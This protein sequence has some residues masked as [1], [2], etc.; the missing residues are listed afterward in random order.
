MLFSDFVS[1]ILFSYIFGCSGLRNLALELETN[2]VCKE[3]GLSKTPFST[4][5]DGFSRFEGQKVKLLFE[6]VLSNISLLQSSYLDELGIFNVID[7]SL[8]PT[9]LPANWTSYRKNK[10]A[11][12]MHFCFELNRMIA[13]EF[14][15][16]NGHSCER[17]IFTQMVH[18]GITYIAD[19]GYFS[20][21]IALKVSSSDAFFILR[22]KDNMLFNVENRLDVT[23]ENFPICFR[24]AS[25]S[26]GK[27]TNDIHQSNIRIVRFEVWGNAFVIATNRLDLTTFQIILLYAY[28]WQI[29]LFFK[30][31]KRTLKG[32][33]LL[34]NTEN[35]V[36]IQFYLL[37]T[38][39][40]L[41]LHLKQTCQAIKNISYFFSDYER[42][43][44]EVY[45]FTGQ[46]PSS[47]IKNAA[48]PFYIFWK[49]SKAWL[50]VLKS[51][52]AQLFDNEII[53]ILS[54]A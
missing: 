22:L 31:L 36:Q 42:K 15:V 24:N 20:F 12:K 50:T 41:E 44:T 38:L 40:L 28:R 9:L 11:F 8:F 16:G 3:L 23:G 27:F 49:I 32:C 48:K 21:D 29:E 47:W 25:D 35:G 5:K 14:W 19:R 18:K 6:S 34:N 43:S 51:N 52:I 53:A 1:K 26:I 7:G 2:P 33:H 46:S 13:T 45:Q 4:L 10:N 30:Y 37:L 39:A 17:T 54:T